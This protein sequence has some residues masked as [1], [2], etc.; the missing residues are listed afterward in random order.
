ML[1]F[2]PSFPPPPHLTSPDPGISID[3]EWNRAARATR[4]FDRE[5][6]GPEVSGRLRCSASG[7]GGGGADAVSDV[8]SDLF[9][10]VGARSDD[11]DHAP[12]VDGVGQ[13][14]A[15][16]SS[17]VVVEV[18]RGVAVGVAGGGDDVLKEVQSVDFSPKLNGPPSSSPPPSLSL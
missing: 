18:G 6:D 16:G 17:V 3:P 4:R 2:A 14:C 15:D 10:V 11:H 13:L 5:E 12:A 9:L 1:L 7:E 8:A